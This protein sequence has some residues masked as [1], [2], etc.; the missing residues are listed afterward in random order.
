MK[1]F[2]EVIKVSDIHV[3]RLKYAVQHLKELFPLKV[4]SLGELSM[5]R[6]SIIELMISRFSKLQD[7]VGSQVFNY[8]LTNSGENTDEMT[9]IDKLNKLEKLRIIESADEWKKMR[10][11]RN[12]LTHEY[13]D[14]PEITVH[15]LN[16]TFDFSNRLL[17][18]YKQIVKK[19]QN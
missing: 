16:Q 9:F 18:A 14:H 8:I 2:S 15:F 10:Q 11:L 17:E 1:D 19:Q 5:E 13:P 3:E 7:Y 12:H 4:D 6:L